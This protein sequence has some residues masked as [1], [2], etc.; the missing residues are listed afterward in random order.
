MDKSDL[1]RA[2]ASQEEVQA[3]VDGKLENKFKI[4]KFLK[5]IGILGRVSISINSFLSL[6]KRRKKTKSTCP[7][8]QFNS[9]GTI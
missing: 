9:H 1:E 3:L 7:D 4:S 6:V 8:A 5:K 2:S